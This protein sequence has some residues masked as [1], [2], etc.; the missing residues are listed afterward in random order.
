M[1]RVRCCGSTALLFA[2]W[3]LTLPGWVWTKAVGVEDCL[4][5]SV[6]APATTTAEPL[7]VMVWIHGGAFITGS[8]RLDDLQYGSSLE[9]PASGV[10]HVAVE[11]RLGILG[12]LALNDGE[13]V[14]NAGLLD[15]ISAL[16]WVRRHIASFG[17]DPDRILVYGHSAGGESVM[18]LQHMPAARHSPDHMRSPGT[19]P[20]RKSHCRHSHLQR[21]LRVLLLGRLL[22][23]DGSG[24]V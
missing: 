11:Y 18:A 14:P 10:V 17:G 1:L 23:G 6:Y 9:M 12:F 2:L 13:T 20:R 7:A 16:R 5:L 15:Q 8:A 22:C 21:G 24:A 4:T 19:Y 3:M